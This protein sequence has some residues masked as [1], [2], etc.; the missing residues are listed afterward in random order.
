MIS[1]KRGS[2]ATSLTPAE[3][4]RLS[5]RSTLIFTNSVETA[6]EVEDFLKGAVAG[7]KV[8]GLH[9]KLSSKDRE[10]ILKSFQAGN[11]PLLVC[12]DVASRGLDT[13]NVEHVIQYEVATDAAS[14]LHRIG[15]TGRYDLLV[16]AMG[17]LLSCDWSVWCCFESQNGTLWPCDD[18]CWS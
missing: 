18:N 6:I 9:K 4:I 7:V 16:C 14:Y 3:V 2:F 17:G 13:I 15:R 1:A 10:K 12:T 5:Q 11:A 8:L